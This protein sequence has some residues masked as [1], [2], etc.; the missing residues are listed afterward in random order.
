MD[1][2]DDYTLEEISALKVQIG[3]PAGICIFNDTLVICD[4]KNSCL[5]LLDKDCNYLKEIGSLGMGPLE[6]SE[7]T[8]IT[9]HDNKI[10]VLDEGNNR[11]QILDSNYSFYDEITL[12]ILIH[13]QGNSEYI[14]LAIDNN[15]II[16]V[17][18]FTSALDDGHIFRIENKKIEKL[19]QQFIGYLFSD[20]GTI[21]AADT[22]E[23]FKEGNKQIARSFRVMA[24]C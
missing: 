11:I 21:Y 3:K 16:Y 8:G 1:F 4:K 12:D 5:V 24:T 22:H 17:S 14:D 9:V 23:L 19:N 10:Y 6:F 20:N 2:S 15:D 18:T 13:K 7:P